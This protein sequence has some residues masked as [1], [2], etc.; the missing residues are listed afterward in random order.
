CAGLA[1][2]GARFEVALPPAPPAEGAPCGLHGAETPEFRFS[3]NPGE[4]LQ[5]LRR[6]ASGGE[7]SRLFLALKNV[8]RRAGEGMVL[9]FD[10]V[11][12]GIGGG[13]AERVGS[14]LASLAAHHQV[15]CITHLP[16][17]AV[18]ADRHFRVAKARR[19]GRTVTT[20]EPL[21]EAA[22]VEEIARMAGGTEVREATRR[23]AR[24]LR[25][26]ARKQKDS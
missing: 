22:R 18:H 3:A 5:P 13:V 25:E 8:L 21:D 7:L 4:A 12:A 6:V 15:L 2:E 14:L 20:V 17:I 1:L 24:A 23:H 11:D 9:V 26:A 10:E 16:Q 19:G